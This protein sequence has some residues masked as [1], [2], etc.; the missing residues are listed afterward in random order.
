MGRKAG[1]TVSVETEQE[2]VRAA[3][4]DFANT[5]MEASARGRLRERLADVTSGG[6]CSRFIQDGAALVVERYGPY[7]IETAVQRN[8]A[9]EA[10][11]R[12]ELQRLEDA[13]RRP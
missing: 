11:V 2:L 4:R 5:R 8:A 6:Q 1:R 10:R 9:T 12:Q 7:R 3:G 13:L